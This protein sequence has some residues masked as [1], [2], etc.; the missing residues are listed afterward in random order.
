VWSVSVLDGSQRAGLYRLTFD[1]APDEPF[2][3]GLDPRESDLDRLSV[4]ELSGL[5]RALVATRDAP[6][7][8]DA[9]APA[10][11]EV[12]RLLA[13]LCLSALCLETLWAAWVGRTRRL[14]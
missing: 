11:G 14:V 10:Q 9:P 7:G 4:N 8:D 3:V 2:A 1:G 13:W 5:H 12:W 6:S